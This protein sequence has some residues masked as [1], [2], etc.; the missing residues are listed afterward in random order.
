MEC[1]QFIFYI[2]NTGECYCQIIKTGKEVQQ[3]HAWCK[4]NMQS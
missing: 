4:I 2:K 1:L 3:S